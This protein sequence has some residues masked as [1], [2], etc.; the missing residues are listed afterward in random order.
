MSIATLESD[1]RARRQRGL[2]RQIEQLRRRW[3]QAH[4]EPPIIGDQEQYNDWLVIVPGME[5]PAGW[6][7]TICTV[8][9]PI[10]PMDDHAGPLNGFFVDLHLRLADGSHPQY[11]LDDE[12]RIVDLQRYLRKPIGYG[13]FDQEDY[14]QAREKVIRNRDRH[15]IA[16][17]P[18]WQGVTRFWW[19]AQEYNPNHDT[20]YTAAMLCRARLRRVM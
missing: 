6:N 15:M 4:Y 10:R 17:H 8:L 3:P 5:L 12:P 11:S 16:G 9:M 13:H 14:E 20:L 7:A 1:W 19:R 2:D 18:Q